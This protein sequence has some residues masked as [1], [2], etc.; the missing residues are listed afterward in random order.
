MTIVD[1]HVHASLYWYE[2]VEV[3]I[4]QMNRNGTDKATLV[5]FRGQTDNS[6]IVECCKRFPGR[7]TPVVVVDTTRNDAPETLEK[8]VKNGAEGIRLA[9]D[10]RSPGKDPLAIWRKCA[11]L[12]ISVTCRGDADEFASD[13]FHQFVK[14]LPDVK[15]IIEHL[16]RPRLEEKPPYPT[17][18]KVMALADFPNTYIKVPGLGELCPRPIP[19]RQPFPFTNIPPFIKLT[20]EAFG[21]SR[22]MWGS[23]Y[24]PSSPLEGYANTHVYLEEYLSDFCSVEEKE[25]I[26]GK[27]A[28]S[29]YFRN[30]RAKIAE[31]R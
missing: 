16:G 19:F 7:F 18:H 30:D 14:A 15:I 3:L 20:Y 25:W 22:M 21:A 9:P 31:Q 8:W 1:T 17:Y 13:E 23:N 27:T 12:N 26:F 29:L 10:I 24:P 28:L 11:D 4:F 5:Q 6:Y 2:P